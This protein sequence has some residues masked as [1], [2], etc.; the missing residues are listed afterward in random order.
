MTLTAIIMAGGRGERFWPKSK[1]KSPKQTLTLFNGHP[2][3]S[4]SIDRLLPLIPKDQI[5]VVTE[6]SVA[7]PLRKVIID[8]FPQENIII[9]PIP[10]NTAAC[11]GL[12]TLYIQQRYPDAVV[13]VVCADHLIP[14]AQR[15]RDHLKVAIQLAAEQDYLVT[16]GITPAYPET[17]YGYIETGE[18]IY[19]IQ[20][21]LGYRV[22]RFVEK[23]DKDT[24]QRY[25]ASGKNFWNSGMFV[26]R[27]ETIM[28]QFQNLMPSLYSGL[29]R[30]KTAIGTAQEKRIIRSV[31]AKLGK[32]PIDKGILEK[33][34]RIVMVKSDFPWFDIGS[35]LT[36]DRIRLKDKDGNVILGNFVGIDTRDCILVSDRPLI[37]TIGIQNLVIVATKNAI[38]VCPKER[39]QDVKQI[40]TQ[41]ESIPPFRYYL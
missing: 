23:P 35:W 29:L 26:W 37:A 16:F 13:A 34:E 39:T 5:F 31:Y 4:S 15:F 19:S 33:T 27:A 11:I 9:E 6:R 40:V 17:G 10:R 25:V 18:Q 21:I 12:A 3:I 24:A 28:Q 36:L 1:K 41:L 7:Q 20:N 8:S 22:V 30:I 32:I 2:L 38:L 14:D